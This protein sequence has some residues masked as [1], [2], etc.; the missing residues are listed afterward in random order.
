M[1]PY[2]IHGCCLYQSPSAVAIDPI[3]RYH[4]EMYKDEGPGGL[5]HISIRD[6]D[7]PWKNVFS[8]SRGNGPVNW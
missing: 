3:N 4:I 5:W 7:K 1:R 8:Y 2:V 6:I